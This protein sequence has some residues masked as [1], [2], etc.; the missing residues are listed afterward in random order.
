MGN[1]Y[2]KQCPLDLVFSDVLKICV[3]KDSL[4]D[5]CTPRGSGGG[6]SGSDGSNMGGTNHGGSKPGGSKPDGSK[7]GGSNSGGSS[8]DESTGVTSGTMSSSSNTGSSGSSSN[9]GRVVRVVGDL[10][11]SGENA[12]SSANCP[13]NS[14]VLNCACNERTGCN[15]QIIS[16][17]VCRVFNARRASGQRALA[18]CFYDNVNNW[19]VVNSLLVSSPEA[20]CTP[21]FQVYACTIHYRNSHRER[22]FALLDRARNSCR[23]VSSCQYGRGCRT[24][25]ICR[26]IE[27]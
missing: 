10:S 24:Q 27:E 3:F 7:S 25:A 20:I 16:G 15:G 4:Y 5:D 11:A 2:V 19:E 18:I 8:S 13:R 22:V 21:G 14:V 1:P 17:R 9:Q 23:A 12:R 26:K 6:N